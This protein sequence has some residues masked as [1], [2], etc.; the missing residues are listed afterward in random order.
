MRLVMVTRLCALNE[1]RQMG[2]GRVSSWPLEIVAVVPKASGVR[3]AV[4]LRKVPSCMLGALRL[5]S[6]GGFGR[7]TVFCFL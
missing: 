2:S 7:C 3:A 1:E 6:G 5:G 4:E